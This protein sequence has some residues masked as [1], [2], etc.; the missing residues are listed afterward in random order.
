MSLRK[1]PENLTALFL[2]APAL[3]CKSQNSRICK[4]TLLF[5]TVQNYM[6]MGH[7]REEQFFI[8]SLIC[9]QTSLLPAA[10]SF[11]FYPNCCFPGSSCLVEMP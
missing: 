4:R 8:H 5:A 9:K 11:F 10:T 7:I 6:K 3:T 2:E 1:K